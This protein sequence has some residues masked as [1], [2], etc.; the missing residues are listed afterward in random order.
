M[1]K[2]NFL[3]EALSSWDYVM[4]HIAPKAEGVMLPDSQRSAVTLTLQVGYKHCGN[5]SLKDLEIEADFI[6]GGEH[7]R[8]TVPLTAIWGATTP[9]GRH[10]IWPKDAPDPTLGFLLMA[11]CPVESPKV[12]DE[13]SKQ[14]LK[15]KT[16]RSQKVSHLKRVK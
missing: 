12:R 14:E 7:E 8:C 16:S 3:S 1:D 10:T 6:F 4:V 9:D 5:L 11:S 13:V 15:P 2:F